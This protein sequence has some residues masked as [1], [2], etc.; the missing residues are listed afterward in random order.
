[1]N[2]IETI[3]LTKKFGDFTAINDVSMSV[4]KG[5]IHAICGENGA[6]KSTLMNML[7]GLLKPSSGQ[8]LINEQQ[9]LFESPKD[10]ISKGIGMVH[11]HFKL[12]PSLKVYENVLLGEEICRAG[13]IDNKREKEEVQ[14]T[15]DKFGFNLDA[16]STVSSLSIGE[17]QRVEIIKMLHRDV[18]ILI[19]DEPTAVL[20]PKETTD[21]LDKLVS[22][23]NEGKTIIII[24]HKLDEVKQY[25][26][27]ITVIRKGNFITSL[28]TENVSKEE[29]SKFMVGRDVKVVTSDEPSDNVGD[30]ALELKKI[31]FFTSNGKKVIDN[32]SLNVKFGEVIGIAGIEGN[33]QS[34]L[35]S[36]L[37]GILKQNSGEFLY[38]N[39][40]VSNCSPLILRE[41]GFGLVPEDRYKDGLNADMSIWENMIAGRHNDDSMCEHGFLNK[42]KIK[43]KTNRL[44]EEF[45]IRNCANINSKVSS[46]SGG[47]AQKI[48]MAREISSNPDVVVMSQPTRG[49]DIGS[50]EFIHSKIIEL[51]NQGKAVLI[52]SS[53]LSEVLNLSDRIYVMYQG[54]VSGER[55]KQDT[56]KEDL[57]LL[58][59]GIDQYESKEELVQC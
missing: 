29:I 9:V 37:T 33:G 2:A 25:S 36:I 41:L 18:D 15:I 22:L 35:I 12:V 59:V 1:M 11:Q 53:E 17:Q 40:E 4:K 3:K 21:L 20:T 54:K 30:I 7:F 46:L 19:L 39:R 34:E 26:D 43:E 51:R 14:A 47:N 57:G 23:K 55:L 38:K 8:I 28:E 45:D 52:V 42:A 5:E 16:C 50:I 31:D 48:I 13:Y 6:G 49:V 56:N 44:V 27:N 24:T 58:M 10:A 32:L